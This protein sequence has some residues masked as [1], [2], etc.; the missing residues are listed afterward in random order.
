[1]LAGRLESMLN[2]T[3]G[4]LDNF[5]RFGFGSDWNR[6]RTCESIDDRHSLLRLSDKTTKSLQ[7]GL[8]ILILRARLSNS[9]SKFF[10]PVE[11][12]SIDNFGIF[13]LGQDRWI[14]S[15]EVLGDRSLIYE[16]RILGGSMS[17]C[18]TPSGMAEA[19]SKMDWWES[20]ATAE[21]RRASQSSSNSLR[22]LSLAGSLPGLR[23]S[24]APSHWSGYSKKLSS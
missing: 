11:G 13:Q 24:V 3:N 16:S 17:P 4:S 23:L 9:N 22:R 14:D 8:V 7:D 15:R 18:L 20:S 19:P 5:S 1:M 6:S 2:S 12:Q 21:R 10:P